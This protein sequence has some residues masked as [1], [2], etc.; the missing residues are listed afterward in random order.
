IGFDC[1]GQHLNITSVSLLGAGECNLDQQTP[2]STNTYIQLL[3]LSDYDYAEVLQ[4]KVEILRTIHYCGMHSHI[5]LVKNGMSEYLMETPYQRC[6]HLFTEG[7]LPI[8]NAGDVVDQIKPNSTTSR[9]VTLAGTVQHDGSCKGAQYS[10]PYGTWDDVVVQAIVRITLKSS[11]APVKLDAGRIILRSG[12]VC[13]LSDGFCLDSE[14]GYSFWKPMPTSSCNLHQYDVLYEGPATKITTGETGATQNSPVIYSLTTED[15][16]FALTKTKEQPLCGYTLLRTEHPKLFILEN[17][18]GEMFAKRGSIPVNNLDIFTYVNSKFVYVEKHIRQ[19][20]TSLYHNVMQQ[21]CEL[22]RQVITNTLS[23]ATLQPDEFAYR[24]MKGPGYMAVTAGEAVHVIKCIPVEALVRKTEACYTEL[25][26]TVHNTSLYLTPKSRILTKVGTQKECSYELPTLY[27]IDDTWVQLTPQPHVR[28]LAPQELRPLATLSWKYLTPGPL[29]ASGIY[30]EKDL[31]KLRDYIM[32]PAEK[33]AVLN[34]MA[35][36]LT[37]HS[38]QDGSV[39]LYNLLDEE[40]LKKIAEST[41]SRIWDGFITFGSATAGVMGLFIAIRII[42]L[43]IDTLIHGY[44]LHSAYGCTMYLFGAIW[45]SVTNLLLH[46]AR[47]PSK[48]SRK[49]AQHQDV[50]QGTP[51]Q[52]IT[53]EERITRSEQPPH[54]IIESHPSVYKNLCNMMHEIEQTPPKTS[55]SVLK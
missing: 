35:R 39:S 23:F 6:L 21:R 40:S 27:R 25:P 34:S 47:G 11:F 41:A 29:A 43:L 48:E 12:T 30:S 26:V 53:R 7:T 1:G 28:Q 44:A 4:C 8:G 37:G 2:N 16:T 46:L 18:K 24:L 50:E 3:Q 19:Q 14:D 22:E 54:A 32:F 10:D 51:L 38:V 33:P 9:S 5:S 49:P 52:E 15:I 36:G 42:K 20:M 13:S 45:S 31:E 17:K 55:E